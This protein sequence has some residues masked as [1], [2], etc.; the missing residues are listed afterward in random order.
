[1]ELIFSLA[2]TVLVFRERVSRT[3]LAGIALLS[4]SVVSLV[5][6]A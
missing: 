6:V 3:E 5:L 1:V 4:A 2:V